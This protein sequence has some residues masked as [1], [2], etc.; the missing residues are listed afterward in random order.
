GH[1]LAH[2]GDG[3]DGSEELET[4]GTGLVLLYFTLRF[5]FLLLLPDADPG[6]PTVDQPLSS[7]AVTPVVPL[8]APS[9]SAMGSAPWGSGTSSEEGATATD[10]AT[11]VATSATSEGSASSQPKSKSGTRPPTPRPSTNGGEE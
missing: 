1:T 9:P 2:T 7:P 10:T 3:D 11:L 8:E 5:L 4:S 6:R